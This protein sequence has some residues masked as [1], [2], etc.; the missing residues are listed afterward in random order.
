MLIVPDLLWTEGALRPGLAVE[1]TAGRVARLRPANGARPDHAPHLLIPGP[2]DLQVN[3]GGG[4]ML[5][6]APTPDGLAR[7]AAAHR[8]RGTGEILATLITDAPGILDRAVEAM[9]A[10][11]GI[12]GL[13]GLHL[14]GPAIS[15]ERRGT[16]AADHVRPLDAHLIGAVSRL[17]RAGW[18]VLVTLAPERADPS[19]LRELAATGAVISAG[20]SAADAAT[21]RDA[22]SRGVTCV[23]HLFNA[24]EQMQSRAPGLLGAAILSE[25]FCGIIADGH[26]VAPEMLRIA[27]A[28]RP[29]PDRTFLVSDAM[30]TVGGP[31]RFDLYGRPVT[32]QD[33][34]LV[35]AEGNLA[36][37]H[38]DMVAAMRHAW[39]D[40][41]VSL[42]RAVAMATDIPRAALG[43]PPIRLAPG[44][45][46][47]RLTALDA[48]LRHV[49]FPESSGAYTSG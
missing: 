19:R 38:L 8:R 27:L 29:R 1:V 31:D 41:G 20:H 13:L 45:P 18:P 23:T 49:P 4:T 3:G 2:T 46:L 43:L 33:G 14:E 32:M 7:I 6:D 47:G 37:A 42:D 12:P 48:E 11:R 30:A 36:G 9:L 28:A 24:M 40:L 25:A 39:R 35:N 22:L 10:A 21:F 34:R 5:N 17:R 15:P 44:L 16:H 26:H